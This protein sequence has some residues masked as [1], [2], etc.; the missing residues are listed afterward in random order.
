MA[1]IASNETMVLTVAGI[2]YYGWKDIRVSRGIDR[3]AA[4]FDIALAASWGT[5]NKP[6]LVR[7]FDPCTVSIGTDLVLTGYVDDVEIDF[8]AKA[9]SIRIRGRSKT[10]DVIDCTPDL[11]SGQ[12]NGY[13]LDQIARAIAT[14]FGI[15]VV[16]ATDVG[17]AFPEATIERHETGFEFLERHA[18]LR[19]ILLSDDEYGRLVLT[20]AGA[21]RATDPLV[22]RGVD[23]EAQYKAD[24][25]LQGVP[26]E[27]RGNIARARASLN[28]A[29]QFSDY[30][31]KTQSGEN[32]ATWG[33]AGG[34]GSPS[35]TPVQNQ[36]ATAT[37]GRA[38]DASVPRYR[39]HTI[40]AESG[41]DAAMA[42]LR[43]DWQMRYNNARATKATITVRG[44]RQ[45]DGKLWKIN[46]LTP[47]VADWLGIDRELLIA[48]V[49]YRLGNTEG[50]LT[51]MVLGPVE[52]F[53]PDPGQ[54]HVRKNRGNRS[55]WNGAGGGTYNGPLPTGE[56]APGDVSP[57]PH[58]G[59]GPS[60]E[61]GDPGT[62]PAS[63]PI[64]NPTGDSRIDA[65]NTPGLTPDQ[66]AM[67]LGMPAQPATP[68]PYNI[69]PSM[70]GP[71]R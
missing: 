64:P 65:A 59:T 61:A 50:R 22:Q 58:A 23:P 32:F 49:T 71:I 24:P 12:F 57:D 11:P 45:T 67:F 7:K 17:E 48:H 39:P 20:R 16:V 42:Q 26:P 40:I 55:D 60:P 28:G 9:H 18:R 54:V 47:L 34:I 62:A 52:G 46:Q 4:D 3:M 37:N 70:Q 43:A 10:E 66:R 31:V 38:H 56:P 5:D 2:Q 53:T 33:G 15:D 14:P 8:D 69:P 19:S 13:T 25:L 44:W 29:K 1:A 6:W 63:A 36:V 21:D 30:F 27:R 41:L 68:I 51:E 35:V